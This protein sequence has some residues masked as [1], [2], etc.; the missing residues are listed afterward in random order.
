MASSGWP[1][2]PTKAVSI[3]TIT[4]LEDPGEARRSQEKPGR[5]HFFRYKVYVFLQSS[6][7]RIS[8][9]HRSDRRNNNTTHRLQGQQKTTMTL[10]SFP[11]QRPTQQP[12]CK[13]PLK[14]K[15]SHA[16]KNPTQSEIW[17]LWWPGSK[18][19]FV[20]RWRSDGSVHPCK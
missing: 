7:G 8:T 1:L 11:T 9:E 18:L 13:I 19:V 14:R 5:T 12:T 4:T 3:G 15:L 2:L 16:I 20:F 10:P 17:T 6:A